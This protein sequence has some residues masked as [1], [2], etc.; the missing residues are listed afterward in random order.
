[1]WGPLLSGCYSNST[2]LEPLS[3]DLLEEGDVVKVHQSVVLSGHVSEGGAVFAAFL[4]ATAETLPGLE[5]LVNPV[6]LRS[7]EGNGI[8]DVQNLWNRL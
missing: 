6:G 5:L 8:E 4:V 3:E 1:M 2:G 7:L